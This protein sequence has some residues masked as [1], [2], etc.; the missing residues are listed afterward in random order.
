MLKE[1]F[2]SNKFCK[3]IQINNC[4]IYCKIIFF[5][6]QLIYANL[7]SLNENKITIDGYIIRIVKVKLYII[8][9]ESIVSEDR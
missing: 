5:K 2:Y 1:N 8:K 6:K 4:I 7:K 3:I 9:W